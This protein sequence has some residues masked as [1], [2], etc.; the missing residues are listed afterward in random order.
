MD[1][2]GILCR[3]GLYIF[4]SSNSALMILMG[5]S[6]VW[7]NYYKRWEMQDKKL[8]FPCKKLLVCSQIAF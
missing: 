1:D 2:V 5:L 6:I 8:L 7:C 4:P 3:G